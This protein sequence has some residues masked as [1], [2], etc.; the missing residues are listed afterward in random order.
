MQHVGVPERSRQPPDDARQARIELPWAFEAGQR[1]QPHVGR[2]D[3]HAQPFGHWLFGSADEHLVEVRRERIDIAG[4]R[5]FRFG[6]RTVREAPERR[7]IDDRERHAAA[8][9]CDSSSYKPTT[10]RTYTSTPKRGSTNS[11][12]FQP[13]RARSPGS[14]TTRASARPSESASAGGTSRPVTLSV[15][16]SGMPPTA[17]ATTGSPAPIASTSGSGNP[18][19]SEGRTKRSITDTRSPRSRRA[20]RKC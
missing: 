6:Q 14:A 4:K 17:V 7:V 1:R 18:S 9:L 5:S 12:A 20:P 13:S 15:T 3:A 2:T 8:R 10:V 16:T 11:R 19:H